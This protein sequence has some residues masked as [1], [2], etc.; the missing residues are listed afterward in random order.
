MALKVPGLSTLAY[1][2]YERQLQRDLRHDRMP[3][4]IGVVVDGNRRW[5]KL[6]DSSTADGHLAGAD[7]I[8]EFIGWCAELGVPTVTLY[9]LSTDNMNR[10]AEELEQLMEIIADTLDR[11]AESRPNGGAVRVHPV[12][13]P[14]LLPQALA[15]RL[16]ALTTDD[17]AADDAAAQ[18]PAAESSSGVVST[19]T[20]SLR[21][22]AGK[23]GRTQEAPAIHV[24]VAVGYGGRQ[25]IVDAVKALLRE[26]EERGATLDE[27][28]EELTPGSIS[29]WLYTRG[30]PDPDLIIRTSGEQRLSG[31]LMWQSVY[32][33][34]YFCEALWPDFRRVDFIRALRDYGQRQRRY[35]S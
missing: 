28:A 21:R 29:S 19:A 35:G 26:A 14:E 9:M 32:S 3:A 31:F 24:N 20:G 27:V 8:V 12:G 15:S 11:L 6:A 4:H 33:E 22:I 5:A 16:R 1:R 18:E 30:Q 13:Q 10:S 7:K 2:L 17:D 23:V 25:E 34:F